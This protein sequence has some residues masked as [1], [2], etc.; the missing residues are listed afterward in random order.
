[1]TQPNTDELTSKPKGLLAKI[2]LMRMVME[3]IYFEKEAITP[4]SQEDKRPPVAKGLLIALGMALAQILFLSLWLHR[5]ARRLEPSEIAALETAQ[6]YSD[7]L[8]KGDFMGMLKSPVGE[9]GAP[10]APFYYWTLIPAV[11]HWPAT[12]DS[13][14]IMFTS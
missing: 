6:Y 11:R 13:T 12:A 2:R 4:V 8:G 7:T 3:S 10:V 1:M 9:S 5:D 14:A